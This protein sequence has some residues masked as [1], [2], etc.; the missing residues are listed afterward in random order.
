MGT[1]YIPQADR[2]QQPQGYGPAPGYGQQLGYG[3]QPGY[4]PQPPMGYGPG[5]GPGGYGPGGYPG[6]P[7][8]YGYPGNYG[9]PGSPQPKPGGFDAASAL[10]G[11]LGKGEF[12]KIM[13][14]KIADDAATGAA[15][16]A[17]GGILSSLNAGPGLGTVFGAEPVGSAALAD[18]SS[19]LL[20]SGGYVAPGAA[21][22]ANLGVPGMASISP[23]IPALAA[24]PL[25]AEVATQSWEGVRKAM[26]GKNLS[27][28]E[29][30]ALALPTFGGSFL[31]NPIKKQFG[32]GK[33][34][35]QLRRDEARK[36]IRDNTG[37]YEGE[38]GLIPVANGQYYDT[39]VGGPSYNINWKDKTAGTRVGAAA[40]LAIALA[41]GADETTRRQIQSELANALNAGNG[42]IR[43]NLETLYRNSG[44]DRNQI[45]EG[46][47]MAYQE[48][49]ISREDADA[50]QADTD[51]VYG[52]IN[53]AASP[54]DTKRQ[55][56]DP[57][58]GIMRD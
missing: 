47:E 50:A 15:S 2:Q 46:I 52:V 25:A 1:G 57:R 58:F 32:S 14:K 6:Y 43:A 7:G 55:V 51:L 42:D 21:G 12:D 19:G 56:N 38:D 31:Y 45:W 10:T 53:P 3:Q 28:R 30:I 29:Q 5:Y 48:G 33:G 49:K 26:D 16:G 27:T 44:L 11:L 17:G 4:G 20:M 37:I 22:G 41:G 40:P 8:G 36:Y 23:A 18:G 54:E 24:I 34:A 39:R 13:E 35:A 9:M